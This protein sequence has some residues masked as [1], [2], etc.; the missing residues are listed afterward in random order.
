MLYMSVS[1]TTP[2]RFCKGQILMSFWDEITFTQDLVLPPLDTFQLCDFYF[3]GSYL[4]ICQRK[5]QVMFTLQIGVGKVEFK[6]WLG[7]T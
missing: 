2:Q 1:F 7:N 3:K 4:N 6:L 5:N